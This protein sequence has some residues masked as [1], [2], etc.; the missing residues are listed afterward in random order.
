[1]LLYPYFCI[2]F[3]TTAKTMVIPCLVYDRKEQPAQ[4]WQGALT[5]LSLK[6]K[7]D[8]LVEH[9]IST[10]IVWFFLKF[11]FPGPD[12]NSVLH[13]VATSSTNC[14]LRVYQD[15]CIEQQERILFQAN[16]FWLPNTDWP[17]KIYHFVKKAHAVN[18]KI[19]ALQLNNQR[20]YSGKNIPRWLSV[21]VGLIWTCNIKEETGKLYTKYCAQ[22]QTFERF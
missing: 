22:F 6:K 1:M 11:C 19:N 5:L 4:Y 13:N 16:I 7:F 3:Q 17:P 20:K 14:F 18:V 8:P 21:C 15:N 12:Q 10:H 9:T 2:Y